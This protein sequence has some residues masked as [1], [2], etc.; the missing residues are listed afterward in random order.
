[1]KPCSSY[2]G[3]LGSPKLRDFYHT[4]RHNS[5]TTVPL[6]NLS[7]Q[8]TSR[9]TSWVDSHVPALYTAPRRIRTIRLSDSGQLLKPGQNALMAWSLTSEITPRNTAATLSHTHPKHNLCLLPQLPR[10]T[11][12]LSTPLESPATSLDILIPD[13]CKGFPPRPAME[14]ALRA[15]QVR[16]CQQASE[17]PKAEMEGRTPQATYAPAR[18]ESQSIHQIRQ[19]MLPR[20]SIIWHYKMPIPSIKTTA[21]KKPISAAPMRWLNPEHHQ[22]IMGDHETPNHSRIDQN[23]PSQGLQNTLAHLRFTLPNRVLTITRQTRVA[24]YTLPTMEGFVVHPQ[25]LQHMVNRRPLSYT[26]SRQP[27]S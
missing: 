4:H 19:T 17:P 23:L 12:S 13:L 7:C 3:L 2:K 9:Q 8:N 14:T 5:Q 25:Q 24:S 27:R 26:S 1:M 18:L 20:R 16:S 6:A 10:H 22:S 21:E 11:A 15:S